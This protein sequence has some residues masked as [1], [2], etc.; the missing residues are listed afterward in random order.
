MSD[1]QRMRNRSRQDFRRPANKSETL[2]E[3]RYRNQVRRLR[4]P[5]QLARSVTARSDV[6]AASDAVSDGKDETHQRLAGWDTALHTTENECDE[7]SLLSE[8]REELPR[9]F[10]SPF[11]LAISEVNSRTQPSGNPADASSTAM[12]I[13][14][15]A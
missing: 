5:I 12:P 11:I 3:F 2:D 13:I 7:S 9:H 4:D 10:S 1:S 14:K 6:S 8:F 15:W